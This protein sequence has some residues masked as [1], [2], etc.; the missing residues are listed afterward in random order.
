[1]S[2]SKHPQA[3]AGGGAKSRSAELRSW[4]SRPSVAA[5]L[6]LME[7]QVERMHGRELHPQRAADRSWRYSPNEVSTLAFGGT[8][9]G[10]AAARVFALFEK[11]VPS[12]KVVIETQQ[13][14]EAVMALREKWDRMAGSMVLSPEAASTL[15]RLLGAEA[16]D[17]SEALLAALKAHSEARFN[18]GFREG[19]AYS[20]DYGEVIN[21]QTGERRR[22]TRDGL[23]PPLA[24][25][26]TPPKP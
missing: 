15:R 1:M 24:M 26:S 22:I 6:R 19:E 25:D 14:P 21:P 4:L 20:A 12:Q 16:L 8:A 2:Q 17:S 9:D 13:T 10:A 7:E 18:A 5:L 11:E 23:A 3:D